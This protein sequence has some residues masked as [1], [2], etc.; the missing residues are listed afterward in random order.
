MLFNSTGSFCSNEYI[1]SLM[2]LTNQVEKY[3]AVSNYE[4]NKLFMV[5]SVM[6][7]I[8][9]GYALIIRPFEY[10]MHDC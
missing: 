9:I 3:H 4:P 8:C 1:E 2:Y 5:L 6:A 7:I 10:I